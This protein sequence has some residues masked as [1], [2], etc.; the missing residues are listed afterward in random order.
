MNL[1]E[2][3]QIVIGLFESPVGFIQVIPN[4]NA[5]NGNLALSEITQDIAN[6]AVGEILGQQTSNSICL[7][8]VTETLNCF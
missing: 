4:I 1:Y 6:K 2:A 7:E 5:K 8:F 3:K